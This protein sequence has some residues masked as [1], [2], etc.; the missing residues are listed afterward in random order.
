[1][2]YPARRIRMVS[3]IPEYLSWRTHSSLS[4][5]CRQTRSW[6]S[7]LTRSQLWLKKLRK[8]KGHSCKDLVLGGSWEKT[9]RANRDILFNLSTWNSLRSLRTFIFLQL[10][11]PLTISPFFLLFVHLNSHSTFSQTVLFVSWSYCGF[12]FITHFQLLDYSLNSADQHSHFPDYIFISFSCFINFNYVL[13]QI[14]WEVFCFPQHQ[15][16]TGNMQASFT[17]THY[18]QTDHRWERSSPV[19]I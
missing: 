17:Q 15:C 16:S 3:I 1:M 5:S 10:S 9:W 19:V 11:N 7:F 8:V 18:K 4:N 2:G 12:F 6:N 13:Q 14:L